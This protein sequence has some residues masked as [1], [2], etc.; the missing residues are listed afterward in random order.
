VL[1]AKEKTLSA[2]EVLP[3]AKTRVWGL[4]LEN[5]NGIGAFRPASSTLH[6]GWSPSY[7]GTASGQLDQRYYNAGMGRFFNVDPGGAGTFVASNPGSANR[8]AYVGGDPVNFVDR[9]GLWVQQ[10]PDDSD[11]DPGDPCDDDPTQIG[12]LLGG[13]APSQGSGGGGS[14]GGGSSASS[15]TNPCAFATLSGAQQ[16]LLG[17]G[18]QAYWAGLPAAAQQFFID[19][20]DVAAGLSLSLNGL[21][22]QVQ[23]AGLNNAPSGTDTELV[24]SGSSAAIAALQNS[25]GSNFSNQT[26][27]SLIGTPHLLPGQ[28]S[29]GGRFDWNNRQNSAFWAMQVNTSA[30]AGI[31]EIDIDQFNPNG[32]LWPLMG[33]GIQTGMHKIS[34]TDTNPFAVAKALNL[35]APCTGGN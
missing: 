17:A 27:S 6:W 3:Q 4:P 1:A 8:Y 32:G 13:S 10:N 22:A 35:G 9:R 24:L 26:Q 23:M 12:C 21:T 14:V 5:R 16:A 20:T 15:S 30:A 29:G 7:D 25:L 31:A 33:H 34:K 2:G 11:F 19:V 18:G 28:P